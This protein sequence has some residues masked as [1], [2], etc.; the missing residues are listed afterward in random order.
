MQEGE[1][2]ILA[3]YVCSWLPKMLIFKTDKKQTTEGERKKQ[4]V[5][6]YQKCWS[7]KNKKQTTEGERKKQTNKDLELQMQEGEVGILAFYV[8]SWLPKMLIHLVRVLGLTPE[9]HS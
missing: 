6:G 4:F 5:R 2:G 7:L 1:V 3:F 8:C 9:S